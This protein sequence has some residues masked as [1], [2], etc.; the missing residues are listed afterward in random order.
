MLKKVI[1]GWIA[2]EDAQIRRTRERWKCIAVEKNGDD[3]WLVGR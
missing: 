3:K 1:C 2:V